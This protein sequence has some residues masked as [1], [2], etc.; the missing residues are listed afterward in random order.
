MRFY[1][2]Y[3]FKFLFLIFFFSSFFL[4]FIKF[5]VSVNYEFSNTL[6][7]DV[8]LVQFPGQ[9]RLFCAGIILYLLTDKI[10]SFSDNSMLIL[11]FLSIVLLFLFREY[12]F[13]RFTV[14]PFV[15]SFVI[16]FIVYFKKIHITTFDFSY[17]LYVVH[18]PVIQL[19]VL[20]NVSFLNPYLS[21]VLILFIS[22][23]LSFLLNKYVEKYFI[24]K[25]KSFAI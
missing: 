11:T 22:M 15:L 7:S 12:D 19:C 23:S 10:Q 16:F 3:S 13:F 4:F 20:Y 1:T 17:S 8:L 5:L 24:N 9:L 2:R 18:F 14:Y 6:N 25:G 21:F